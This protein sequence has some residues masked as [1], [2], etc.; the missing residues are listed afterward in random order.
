MTETVEQTR[1][2]KMTVKDI[3][4]DI[5]ALRSRFFTTRTYFTDSIRIDFHLDP[6]RENFVSAWRLDLDFYNK[7]IHKLFND[8]R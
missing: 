2:K 1:V 7:H 4:H 6:L 5:G 8:K 3:T